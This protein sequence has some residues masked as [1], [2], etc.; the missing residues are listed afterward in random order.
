M[1][2]PYISIMTFIMNLLLR[3]HK[4]TCDISYRIESCLLEVNKKDKKPLT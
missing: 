1:S 4:I 3:Q 2:S